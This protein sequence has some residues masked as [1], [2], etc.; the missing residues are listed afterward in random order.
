MSESET[1]KMD[2]E[3]TVIRS[4]ALTLRLITSANLEE[5][6]LLLKSMAGTE[7]M[8]AELGTSYLPRFDDAD[9]RTKYGFVSSLGDTPAGMCLLGISSWTHLRGYTG[10]DTLPN[11]RGK[12]VAPDTKPHL[13]Y[14]AFEIL[15]LNRVETGCLVSNKSSRRSI[16]KTAGFTYEGTLRQFGRNERGE[17]EDEYRWALLRSD[18]ERLYDKSLFEVE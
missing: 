18:W 9:R 4:G 16:E 5:I 13:F 17:F 12:G 7:A 2:N 11:M 10:A 6:R 3:F 8:Q 15:G 14:L 1:Q